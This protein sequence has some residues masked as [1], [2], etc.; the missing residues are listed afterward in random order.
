MTQTG[1][2]LLF[3]SPR[4]LCIAFAAFLSLFALDVFGEGHGF[5]R[6]AMALVM[7]LKWPAVVAGIL[8]LAWR[9]EWIGASLFTVAAVL[10][11]RMALNRNHPDWALVIS[12]PLVVV[13]GLF[14]A[15]WLKR[16]ELHTGPSHRSG[17]R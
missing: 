17:G 1:R 14:L 3:W 8:M 9:W 4:V 2:Q 16:T 15:N 5:W 11:L 10:Y 13:A 12:G 6:T 7:H